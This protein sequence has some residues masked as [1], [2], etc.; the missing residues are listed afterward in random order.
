MKVHRK[1][2]SLLLI[3]QL[4]F[5]EGGSPDPN[6]NAQLSNTIAQA[7]K[8]NMPFASIQNAIK[9]SKVTDTSSTYRP[10][11]LVVLDEL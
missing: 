11:I 7:K 4:Y 3:L 5:A 8:Y 6:F 2:T 9:Q 10:F 1:L